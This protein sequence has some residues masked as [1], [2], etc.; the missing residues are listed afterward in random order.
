MRI[1][2]GFPYLSYNET[3]Y[4]YEN[5][6]AEYHLRGWL[7]PQVYSLGKDRRGEPESGISMLCQEHCETMG[8]LG[9]A[10]RQC[11]LVLLMEKDSFTGWD[12]CTVWVG[13]EHQAFELEQCKPDIPDRSWISSE[14]GSV[15]W[16]ADLAAWRRFSHYYNKNIY[17]DRVLPGW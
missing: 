14:T 17:K 9:E 3:V 12:R 8:L 10:S 7:L 11:P 13:M 5:L 6:T 2:Y 1:R 4:A 16:R 15:D